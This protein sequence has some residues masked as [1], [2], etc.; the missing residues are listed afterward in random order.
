MNIEQIAVSPCSNPD[1][2]LD[3]VLAAYSKLGYRNFECFT[4]WTRSAI[5]YHGDPSYYLDRSRRYAMAFTSFHLPAIAF[6]D[7]EK[8]LQEAITAARFAQSIGAI[9]VLF[10]ASDRPTYIKTA[11]EF[12]D[13]IADLAV[14]PVIQNHWGT[15]LATLEDV[16]EVFEG[17]GDPRIRTLLEVGQF[18]S[19]GV[20]WRDAAEYLGNSIA[21]VH[22]KDQIGSQSVPFGRGEIDLSGL[23]DYL[24]EHGYKGL[25]VVE[26]EVA[27]KERTLEYL[28]DA[29]HYVCTYCKE[30]G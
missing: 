9:I 19:A 3:E 24:D 30:N 22:I 17:I 21:L 14:T 4:S 12:L 1:M 5:D 25:Y 2:T 13:G 10:K 15:P 11:G 7:T 23:F 6:D 20:Y 26:M 16:K 27:D 18:H 29:Y 28:A 8:T